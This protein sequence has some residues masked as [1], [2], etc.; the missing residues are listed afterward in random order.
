MFRL[1]FGPQGTPQWDAPRAGVA[2]PSMLP[3]GVLLE[4]RCLATLVSLI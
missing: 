4:M 2:A 3:P 1:P